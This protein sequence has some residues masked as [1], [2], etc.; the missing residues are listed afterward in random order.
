MKR[1]ASRIA[2]INIIFGI[3]NI[4]ARRCPMTRLRSLHISLFPSGMDV[5]G[6]AGQRRRIYREYDGQ[7][8]DELSLTRASLITPT[9]FRQQPRSEI[10][11][12][13]VASERCRRQSNPDSTSLIP[14]RQACFVAVRAIAADAFR[15]AVI[16]ASCCTQC[17]RR[18]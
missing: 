5:D 9:Y 15:Q 1:A 2:S 14:G 12:G 3:G 7:Y 11:L 10:M 17:R 4:G 16:V 13:G 8:A 6:C 18:A